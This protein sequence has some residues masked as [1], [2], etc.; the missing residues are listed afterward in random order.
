MTD[1]V[2]ENKISESGTRSQNKDS[3]TSEECSAV[4]KDEK[5]QGGSSSISEMN[6]LTIHEINQLNGF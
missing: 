5:V 6:F 3:A 4:I 2:D 1:E